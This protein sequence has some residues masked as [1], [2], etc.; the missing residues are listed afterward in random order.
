M[1]RPGPLVKVWRVFIA[2][3]A[4]TLTVL[5]AIYA[6]QPDVRPLARQNPET[7]AFIE[8]RARQAASSGKPVKL[9]RRWT[10]FSRI[11]PNLQR[12]VLVTEDAAFYSHHGLDLDEFRKSMEVNLERFSF[13]R[14]G[15]TITQQLAKNLYLSPSKDPL[16]KYRELLIARSLEAALTKQR[17]FE[18]YL[19]VI[20]WGDRIY[21][22]DAAARAYF[23]VSA[24]GL[25]AEQSA[26]LAGAIANPRVMR[27]EA[28]SRRLRARQRMILRRM[29]AGVRPTEPRSLAE[30]A[31][32]DAT[33]KAPVEDTPDESEDKPE[34]QPTPQP[35]RPP[36][37]L[38]TLPQAPPPQP[39]QPTQPTPEPPRP[40]PF[41]VPGAKPVPQPER[42]Q[43]N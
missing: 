22:A 19:N 43:K 26:L 30:E 16:R 20:E 39:P 3:L 36:D 32:E 38:P 1:P 9:L 34:P 11:S 41:P 25:S 14:G 28:P 40:Q 23:G 37:P 10:P 18:L 12:A 29:S 24:G 2:A 27:P 4:F 15:S 17:I 35:A 13:A 6:T 31:E 5:F 21:G 33:L 42:S 8:L 7:T